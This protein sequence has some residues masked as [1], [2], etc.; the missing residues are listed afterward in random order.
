M[1]T[2]EFLQREIR[3]TSTPPALYCVG[4]KL[5]AVYEIAGAAGPPYSDGA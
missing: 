5:H 1:T 2:T 3:R 4:R